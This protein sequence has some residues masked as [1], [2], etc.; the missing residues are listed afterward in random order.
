MAFSASQNG[1]TTTS[2]DFAISGNGKLY[3][4]NSIIPNTGNTTGSV[5]DATTPV[6]VDSG[7]IK[8]GNTLGTAAY[9]ATEYFAVAVH[10]NHVPATQTANNLT[11]LRNDNSWFKL[12]KN[13][14]NALIN[15]LDIDD[16][17]LTAND[18]V[19]T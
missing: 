1:D 9:K 11:F 18:Y 16:S 13:E 3:N 2:A 7:V 10:G 5:G 19:I 4:R 12:T 8:A 14:L 17:A 15:L 6:Y